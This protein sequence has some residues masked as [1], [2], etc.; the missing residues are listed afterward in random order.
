MWR[1][2]L[3]FFGHR[4]VADLDEELAFHVDM[5]IQ[6]YLAQGMSEAEA[7]AAAHQRLGDIAIARAPRRSGC[8]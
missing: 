4:G 2:Y 6:D 8:D 5:R 3:R 7:R 1:R